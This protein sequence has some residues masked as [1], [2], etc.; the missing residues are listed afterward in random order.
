MLLSLIF[1]AFSIAFVVLLSA[2]KL[3]PLQVMLMPS[4]VIDS[5]R[6]DG[7]FD[8][9]DWMI[10]RIIGGGFTEG[11]GC[12]PLGPDLVPYLFLLCTF[13]IHLRCACLASAGINEQAAWLALC[14]QLLTQL[15]QVCQRVHMM[16]SLTLALSVRHFPAKCVHNLSSFS[17]KSAHCWVLWITFLVDFLLLFSL[18]SSCFLFFDLAPDFPPPLSSLLD[19]LSPT[20]KNNGRITLNQL[21]IISLWLVEKSMREQSFS[22]WSLAQVKFFKYSWKWVVQSRVLLLGRS[23][24]AWRTLCS[25]GFELHSV[26]QM[27]EVSGL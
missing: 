13:C 25:K 27:I 9:S 19:K 11:L 1:F 6:G 14:L 3:P 26:G 15:A 22:S 23:C 8:V 4:A 12:M 10:G 17:L 20:L 21:V 2:T 16:V 18:S 24:P 7:G 5:M